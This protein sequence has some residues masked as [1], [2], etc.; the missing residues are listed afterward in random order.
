MAESLRDQLETAFEEHIPAEKPAE[1]A[2]Q[3]EA[4]AVAHEAADKKPAAVSSEPAKPGRTAGRQRDESGRLLPGAADPA[5][6]APPVVAAPEVKRA[7]RP[8]SWKKDHWDA[9]DQI[10]TTNP[11]LADYINQRESE[12]AKGVSTYKGEWEKAQPLLEAIAPFR[13]QLQRYGIEPAQHVQRLFNAHQ[14]LAL[15]SPQDK[16]SMFAQLAREYQVPVEGLF[17]QGQDGK[18]YINPQIQ[19]AAPQ[20]QQP[21]QNQDPRAI[22]RGV[23]EEE[24]AVSQV[25]EMA[26]DTEQYPHLEQV[27][28]AMVGLLQ[29][30]QAKNLKDAYAKAVRL[31]DALWQ[32]EQENT[33]KAQEQAKADAERKRVAAA[34]ANAVS[35]RSATPSSQS[36]DGKKGLRATLEDAFDQHTAGRV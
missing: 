13:E 16:L 35:T 21:Q 19:Q 36:G 32:A 2:P 5:A 18:L 33:R 25:Q 30:G 27:R 9:F 8:S 10:A 31:D 20:Q 28:Q 15:G 17:V 22:V 23:L 34:K 12:Y 1:P 7:T 4:P 11:A 6:K 29:A 14:R 24:R 26:Q 3:V